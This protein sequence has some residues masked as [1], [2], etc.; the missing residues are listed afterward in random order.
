[1]SA[2]WRS[3]RE[4][5]TLKTRVRSRLSDIKIQWKLRRMLASVRSLAGACG[6]LGMVVAVVTACPGPRLATPYLGTTL[7]SRPGFTTQPSVVGTLGTRFDLGRYRD[8]KIYWRKSVF[9]MKELYVHREFHKRRNLYIS[10]NPWHVQNWNYLVIKRCN[11]V[12]PRTKGPYHDGAYPNVQALTLA[13]NVLFW[14][15]ASQL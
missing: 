5:R 10:G 14:L 9:A 12:R 3:P 8:E 15:Y 7:G 2:Q 4:S 1:M 11:L 6:L 13:N